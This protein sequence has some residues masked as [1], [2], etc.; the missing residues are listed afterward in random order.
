MCVCDCVY[1]CVCVRDFFTGIFSRLLTSETLKWFH[2]V[3]LW[4]SPNRLPSD[5]SSS[6]K[7][8]S[9]L[10]YSISDTLASV[11]WLDLFLN[12]FGGRFLWKC[13]SRQCPSDSII[14]WFGFQVIMRAKIK[15]TILVDTLKVV[16]RHEMNPLAFFWGGG[17]SHLVVTFS[18]PE[19]FFFHFLAFRQLWKSVI[20]LS[21]HI[22]RVPIKSRHTDDSS[23]LMMISFCSTGFRETRISKTS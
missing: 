16:S 22:S 12:W 19:I 14:F 23:V 17:F 2:R 20:F 21:R 4:L 11:S 6:P 3:N 10:L 13:L 15:N 5:G 18:L 9:R 7:S 8:D 1:V